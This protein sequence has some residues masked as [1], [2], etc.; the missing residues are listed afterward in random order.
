M[1]APAVAGPLEELELLLFVLV[2]TVELVPPALAPVVGLGELVPDDPGPDEV[3]PV[4]DGV[5]LGNCPELAE[6]AEVGV[7]LEPLE[8]LKPDVPEVTV[9]ELDAA[10]EEAVLDSVI[11]V[12]EPLL[13]LLEDISLLEAVLEADAE[14]DE[15]LLLLLEDIS[16]LEAALEAD[17]V[18]DTEVDVLEAAEEDSSVEDELKAMT[19][20]LVAVC[21]EV[22]CSAAVELTSA[23][24]EEV[25]EGAVA[26]VASQ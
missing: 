16:L 12:D 4:A 20:P 15:P 23:R 10:P 26:S 3:V 1:A 7:A 25:D 6:V 8:P 17:S 21:W 22:V 13:P 24:G 18:V 19:D 9:A 5:E 2:D 11:E 14:V